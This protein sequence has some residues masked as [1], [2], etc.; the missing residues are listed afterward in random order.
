MKSARLGKR[1][2]AVEVGN[3]SPHGFW[4]C[5]EG[6]EYFLPFTD[7][8]WF[9]N[10]SIKQICDVTLPHPGHL[11]WPALDI[12]LAVDSIVQPEKYPLVSSVRPVVGRTLKTKTVSRSKKPAIKR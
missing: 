12:D 5:V 8:P 11:Y 2:S 6:Q 9:H 7:F 3:V 1:T 4:L 10:A